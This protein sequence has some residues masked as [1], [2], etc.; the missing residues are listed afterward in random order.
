MGTQTGRVCQSFTDVKQAYNS[1]RREVWII[2][3]LSL[4]HPSKQWANKS[5]MQTGR[6]LS[7]MF[8]IHDGLKQ[9]RWLYV[10]FWVYPRRPLEFC[11]RFG[12]LC[13]FHLLGL[14]VNM[15]CFHIYSQP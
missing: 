8:A 13:W 5:V 4:V 10:F 1:V 9:D 11:Q 3:S 6:H 12:T 2:F 14:G 7:D 15:K